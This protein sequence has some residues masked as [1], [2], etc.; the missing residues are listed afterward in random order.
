MTLDP[1]ASTLYALR[2]AGI[3]TPAQY[4]RA[5]AHPLYSELAACA[6]PADYLVW[7]VRH[8]IVPEERLK[9]AC[10]DLAATTGTG[11]ALED[12]MKTLVS[13]LQ[14]LE[15]RRDD[16]NRERFDPLVDAGL[17]TP[18]ERD[19]ALQRVSS[20]N[21]P[22]SPAAALAWMAL[23][24]VIDGARLGAGA[25]PAAPGGT[26]R[27][28]ILAE[29]GAI[30]AKARAD[31]RR[32]E[33]NANFPGP[34]WLW[35]CA[36]VLLV[37]FVGWLAFENSRVPACSDPEVAETVNKMVRGAGLSRYLALAPYGFAMRPPTP[38]VHDIEEVGLATETRV[39]GCVAKLG[40]A[41]EDVPFAFTITPPKRELEAFTV[42]GA[43]PD[44]V[45]ARFGHLDAK[46]RFLNQAEPIG[47]AELERAF[48][49]GA[50]NVKLERTARE[51]EPERQA[52]TP[53]GVVPERLREIAEIE[54]LEPCREVKKGTTYSCRLLIERNDAL[55]E[56]VQGN[57]HVLI[58]SAFT[59]ERDGATGPW[60][61]SA[62]FA[63]E[64]KRAVTAAR[65]KVIGPQGDAP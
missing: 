56:E 22:E 27:A 52:D 23:S 33:I 44:I 51:P 59:F 37:G 29:A 4:R 24:G 21:L 9:Q 45:R 46:G 34:R 28:D 16:L 60:R 11:T 8:G 30:H 12:D 64:Y 19:Q 3:V 15:S 58:D 38:D 48:R 6:A 7:L 65:A 10:T 14:I 40:V 54:P 61:V 2:D 17:I 26:A 43:D 36:P 53:S 57:S 63:D 35:Y 47:R 32:A 20:E 25:V 41:G 55:V 42:T 13:A 31:I 5:L 39:R 18:E 1:Q 62:S 50:D 49:S